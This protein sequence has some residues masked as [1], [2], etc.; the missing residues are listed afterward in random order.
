MKKITSKLTLGVVLLLATTIANAHNT[1]LQIKGSGKINDKVEIQLLKAEYGKEA[2]EKGTKLDNLK[3]IKIFL[4]DASGSKTEIVMTQTETHWQGFFIPKTTG[5]YTVIGVNDQNEVRDMSKK[6]L[7]NGRSILYL[8]ALYTIKS[9]TNQTV[10]LP[11][12]LTAQKQNASYLLTAFK[13]KKQQ[14]DLNL[15]VINP[16]GWS[17][18]AFKISKTTPKK[19]YLEVI[20]R[21]K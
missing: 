6:C 11:L 20:F 9:A 2:P 12:D 17:V 10:T 14:N 18:N 3:A 13:D 21:N 19:L 5:N 8:K 7:G 15:T 4:I 16:D 1:Y